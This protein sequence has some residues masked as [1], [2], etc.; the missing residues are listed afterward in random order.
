MCNSITFQVWSSLFIKNLGLLLEGVNG[1]C[2]INACIFFFSKMYALVQYE[3]Q[4]SGY[5]S[6]NDIPQ[7]TGE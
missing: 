3:L 1:L 5:T 4:H 2:Q 7:N 6:G